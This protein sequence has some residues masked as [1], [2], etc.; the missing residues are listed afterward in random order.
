MSKYTED[1][2][3]KELETKEYEYGFYTD[4]ESDKF[5][6][7]LN[8]DIVRAISK[9]KNEPEWM[10]EWRLEAFKIWQNM[11]EPEWA[12]VTYIKPDFQNISYYSAPKKKPELESLDQ[13][14]PELLET[15]KKL[16]ISIEEQKRLS[17]VAVDI[18]MDSVSVATT[19]KKTL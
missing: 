10:T 5:P 19:F 18:V 15:F 4:I 11:T 6:V 9:K 1:D 17:G 8:E 7:G 14:D 12:N 13:V 3:K 16:G 2:L